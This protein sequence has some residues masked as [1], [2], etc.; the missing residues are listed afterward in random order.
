[1]MTT[2]PAEVEMPS[3]LRLVFRETDRL[4]VE[5]VGSADSYRVTYQAS[6]DT[7]VDSVASVP[8]TTHT[9]GNLTA[10]TSYA[11]RVYSI[12]GGRES[13]PLEGHW[14]TR[15]EAPT[16]LEIVTMNTDSLYATWN[17]SS[18]ADF[19]RVT[20]QTS[21][22]LEMQ[23]VASIAGATHTI[24]SLSPGTLYTVRVYGIKDLVEGEPLLG[25]LRTEPEPPTNLQFTTTSTSIL[26]ISWT[27]SG[28]ADTY[29][30]SLEATGGPEVTYS[31]L[32][33]TEYT[34]AGLSPGT[35]YTVRVYS[36][37]NGTEGALPLEGQ[38]RTSKLILSSSRKC[39]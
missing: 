23:S 14:G 15:P 11:V 1:M 10:G 29:R 30:V 33:D 19:Y 13:A 8:N 18:S 35:L 37:K 16:N 26:Q 12:E 6:G 31:V 36:R 32:A 27:A 2:T 34:A 21:D 4:G 24:G 25:D 3:G 28:S 7:E 39:F 20:Y 17:A 22:G 5:W 38:Q 9:I